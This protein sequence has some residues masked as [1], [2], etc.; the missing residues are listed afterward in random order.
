ML[1]HTQI[2]AVALKSTIPVF[3]KVVLKSNT[4]SIGLH[5][6]VL[7]NV[8]PKQWW[9][10]KSY[11]QISWKINDLRSHPKSRSTHP[12]TLPRGCLCIWQIQLICGQYRFELHK[13]TD[14]RMFFN[15]SAVDP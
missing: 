1:E 12:Y 7:P 14:M 3:R 15:K 9:N 6:C 8:T 11:T 13:F 10:K 2:E 5:A 4:A